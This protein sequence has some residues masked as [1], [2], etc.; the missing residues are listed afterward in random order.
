MLEVS[1][2]QLQK[3]TNQTATDTIAPLIVQSEGFEL[4]TAISDF[5]SPD[6]ETSVG[7][8]IEPAEHF[9]ITASPLA[10]SVPSI[11]DEENE[12]RKE[13]RKEMIASKTVEPVD[14]A[15]ERAIGKNDSLYTN[16]I[17]LIAITK[18]K[19]ARIEIKVDGKKTGFA[20]GFMVSKNLM[21]T[22]WHVFPKKEIA[23]TSEVQF[24][25]EFDNLGHPLNPVIFKIDDSKFYNNKELDYCF[26]G[27]VP[28]DIT[29]EHYLE[30]ISYLYLDKTVGKLGEVNVEK[31]NIIHHPLGD[32][33][34]ISIREN[35]FV[36][37][38]DNKI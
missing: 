12:K 15:Y 31:L 16:F 27:V 1:K 23:T 14:F 38:D 19:V 35:L 4:A 36:G 22:N 21:L 5:E 26:V 30:D 7:A 28:K 9:K 20:T 6:V 13:N 24:F 10:I 17:E 8:T 29:N 34:Q 11:S 37:I 33:K 18:R 2:N 3:E 25:Y 32:Y